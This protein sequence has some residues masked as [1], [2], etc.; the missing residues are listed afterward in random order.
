MSFQRAG[1]DY[2]QLSGGSYE[3]SSLAEKELKESTKKREEHFTA[4]YRQVCMAMPLEQDVKTV[5]R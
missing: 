1:F 4:F 5:V 2:I 3:K